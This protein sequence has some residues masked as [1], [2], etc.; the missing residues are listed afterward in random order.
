MAQWVPLH[1]FGCPRITRRSLGVRFERLADKFPGAQSDS[2]CHA[3]DNSTKKDA[4]GKLN[5]TSRNSQVLQSHGKREHNH[6]PLHA[7]TE[8]TGVLKVQVNGPNEHTAGE[9]AGNDITHQ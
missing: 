5:N 7:N 1:R 6:E 2:E 4:E 3:K 8:E 9:K